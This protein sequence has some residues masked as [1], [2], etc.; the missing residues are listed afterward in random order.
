MMVVGVL[1]VAL[2]GP[3]VFDPAGARCHLSRS[4]LDDVNTDKKDW[5]N[6]DTGGVEP[7]KLPCADAIRLADQIPLKE[8]SDKT[9][10]VPGE[11]ALRLQAGLAVIGSL[12]QSISGMVLLRTLSRRSRSLAIGFSA[13]GLVLRILGILSL[14]VFVFVIYALAFSPASREL[15]PKPPREP[16]EPPEP[17]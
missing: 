5:N 2:S 13:A 17:R 16:R 6:V 8:K 12:G 1:S 10:S 15:W 3:A 9:A 7:K 14:G 11:G 4:W